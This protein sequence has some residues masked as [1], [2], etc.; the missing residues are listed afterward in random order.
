MSDLQPNIFLLF[1]ELAKK[2]EEILALSLEENTN[3]EVLDLL[4]IQQTVITKKIEVALNSKSHTISSIQLEQQVAKCLHLEALV[5]QKM[6]NEQ[7]DAAAHLKNITDGEKVRN[8]YQNA[9]S[10]SDG[11][12]IDKHK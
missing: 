11:Y 6:R 8:S 7:L 3:I 9:Y 10:N 5:R 2:T 4:Q 1:D 12:F